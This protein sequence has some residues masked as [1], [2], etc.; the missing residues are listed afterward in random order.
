[1]N[2]NKDSKLQKIK[3]EQKNKIHTQCCFIS[4]LYLHAKNY[5]LG[6][7]KISLLKM[8]FRFQSNPDQ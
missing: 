2:S 7:S 5:N 1:M 3:M 8:F 6:L 4:F